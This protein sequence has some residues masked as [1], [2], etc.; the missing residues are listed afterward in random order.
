[1]KELKV[2]YVDDAQGYLITTQMVLKK[3]FDFD[4]ANNLETG[5]EKIAN[6]EYNVIITDGCLTDD[7]DDYSG[8]L[9]IAK[10]ASEKGSYV[11]GLSSTPKQ[12]Y[13]IA[14]DYL[15]INYQK[16]HDLMILKYLIQNQPDKKEWENYKKEK[17]ID[18]KK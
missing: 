8:G 7:N 12:F 11:I 13:E 5:L 15:S 17:N 14:K 18:M 9:E 10:K 1:M 2:L 4:I 3:Y 16:P 6:K